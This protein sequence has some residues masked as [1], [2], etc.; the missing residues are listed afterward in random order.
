MKTRFLFLKMF[1]LFSVAAL[2]AGATDLPKME[3]S[4]NGNEA[5]LLA[6]NSNVPKTFEITVTNENN[7]VVFFHKTTKKLASYN[8]NLDFSALGNGTYCIC[9]NYGNQSLNNK[10]M[11]SDSKITTENVQHLYEPYMKLDNG[12]LNVSFLNTAQK[13]VFLN[14]YKNGEHVYGYNLGKK[15][16]IHK[17]YDISNLTSGEYR[18]VVTDDFKDH[19]FT[20]RK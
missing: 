2:Y 4:Q 6:F 1:V 18:V 17:S 3:I 5:A 8:E 16:T 13:G 20:L 10:I 15:L 19:I 11:V 12:Q 9:I 14:I 7:A